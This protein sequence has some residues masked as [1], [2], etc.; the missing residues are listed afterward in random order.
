MASFETFFAPYRDENG[1]EI[2]LQWTE[3]KPQIVC[4]DCPNQPVWCKHIK[5]ALRYRHELPI[6][7][8]ADYTLPL[9]LLLPMFP[10]SNQYANI[11]LYLDGDGKEIYWSD[12][13]D[14][15]V[16]AIGNIQPGE[17]IMVIRALMVEYMIIDFAKAGIVK[18][19]C[20]ASHHG[21]SAQLE[22]DLRIQSDIFRP[23]N[24][25]S[26]YTTGSCLYCATHDPS[27][28]TSDLVPASESGWNK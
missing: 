27:N 19:Q 26:V 11:C 12:A 9:Y 23:P 10:N 18:P 25:W 16:P 28:D 4:N 7:W 15:S 24:L 14:G 21:V 13:P 3:Q 5:Y 2:V 17:G 20:K 8:P 22:W 1:Y 6:L